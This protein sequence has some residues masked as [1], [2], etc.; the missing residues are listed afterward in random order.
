[1]YLCFD[2]GGTNI[3][4]GI[5]DEVGN[6]H[7][8]KNIP[9]K[10]EGNLEGVLQQFKEIAEMLIQETNINSEQIRGIGLGVPGFVEMEEGF[11]TE[12]VNLGWHDVPISKKLAE[13]VHYP[14]FVINDANAAALG[15]MWRGAGQNHK[16]L[17]C[18]TLGTGIGGG[19]I[20]NGRIH[21]GTGGYA[22]EIGH[23]HVKQDGRQCN[24]GKIG[25]LETEASAN[26][27][28]YYGEKA[29]A[30]GESAL[31]ASIREK[32]GSVT[33]KDVVDA[34]RQ[35][36]AASLRILD[37]AAYYLGRTLA[38]IY[39]VIAPK[40]IVI[41]GGLAAAGDILFDLIN[42]W[43]NAYSFEH[44]KGQHIIFPAELGNDAGMIGLAKLVDAGLQTS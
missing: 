4:A 20:V 28:A 16:D 39:M 15:E 41:G 21:N 32:T 40:R 27:L 30:D 26:A 2:L 42:K 14:S 29:A 5:I 24:C 19:V 31:L 18:I 35:G 23:I 12:A 8:K 25:C 44:L 9:T 34:A 17:L 3:K 13:Y 43:F 7:I 10:V 1:M 38:N 37:T 22:G 11:I 36:D 6:I 33:S